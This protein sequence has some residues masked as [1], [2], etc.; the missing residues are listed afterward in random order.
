MNRQWLQVVYMSYHT[1][2]ILLIPVIYWPHTGHT[3][4]TCCTC[5]N[6]TTEPTTL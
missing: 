4:Q 2:M 5:D 6:A 1:C 3:N